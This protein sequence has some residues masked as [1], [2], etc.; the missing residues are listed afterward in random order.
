MKVRILGNG[1]AE[2]KACLSDCPRPGQVYD[3]PAALAALSRS[4]RTGHRRNAHRS[5]PT[6]F[7]P[8]AQT[9]LPLTLRPIVRQ[10]RSDGRE[11]RQAFCS[12]CRRH[13]FASDPSLVHRTFERLKHYLEVYAAGAGLVAARIVGDLDVGDVAHVLVQGRHD[14]V[15]YD[16]RV[17]TS[18]CRWRLSEPTS[19]MISTACRESR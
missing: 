15:V 7:L 16:V 11:P 9:Q 18:N 1:T 10:S 19:S 14:I 3:L 13:V 5:A 2:F 17:D 4:R 8:R 6:T 12:R